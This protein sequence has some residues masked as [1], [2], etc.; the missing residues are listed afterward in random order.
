VEIAEFGQSR[1]DWLREFL[2]LPHGIPSHDTFGIHME[3]TDD[4]WGEIEIE[5]SFWQNWLKDYRLS[6]QDDK[7]VYYA[8]RIITCIAVYCLMEYTR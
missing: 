4:F 2:E 3:G 6:T 7:D 5:F 8:A 1:E